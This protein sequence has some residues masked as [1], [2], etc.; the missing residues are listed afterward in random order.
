MAGPLRK[1]ELETLERIS[2]K[3]MDVSQTDE[4][5]LARLLS[6]GLVEER[7]GTWTVSSRGSME[8]IRRKSVSRTSKR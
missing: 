7:R 3:Q 8:L 5:V 4:N 1:E 2:R 6:L